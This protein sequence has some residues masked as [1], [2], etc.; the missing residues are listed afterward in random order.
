MQVNQPVKICVRLPNWLG[1]AVMSL[2]FL[3]LLRDAYP[4]AFISVVIKKGL[5]TLVNELHGVDEVFV[6]NKETYK[7]IRGVWKYGKRLAERHRYD[8]FFVL[9]DS[10][11]SAMM[12]FA[13]HAKQ[14]IGFKKEGRSFLL[15]KTYKKPVGKHRV[16][17]YASL[18]Q[19]FNPSVSGKV[20]RVHLPV[21]NEE[22]SEPYLIVNI[23]SESI[24][25]RL[26]VEKA[27]QLISLVQQ[28]FSLPIKL[29]GA[30]K[31]KAFVDEVIGLLPHQNNIE[32][33]AGETSLHQLQTLIQN[34]KGMISSDSGPAHIGSASQIPLVVITG[35]GNETNT[36][37]Y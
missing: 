8:L 12:A 13:S 29:I 10:F 14:R 34:A 32:N 22:R 1:D 24:T 27:V 19:Q 23:N 28:E 11:S 9:P 16:E 4:E 15:T 37:P 2:G 20:P 7:G 5:E 35:A 18:L 21:M 17:D 26:P 31:E 3:Q 36:G 6:F 33:V 25:S 30:Q